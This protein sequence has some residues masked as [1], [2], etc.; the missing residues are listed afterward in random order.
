M[1]I[2]NVEDVARRVQYVAAA[3]QTAFDYTF[4][5]FDDDDLV[6][7]VDGVVQTKT[8]H[9]TLDG[10]GED[11]GGTVTF[12]TPMDGDEVV[13][14]Y[15]DTAIQRTSDL[16]QN[17]PLASS[18]LN[19][20]FDRVTV[21]L[22]ELREKIGRAVRFPF[23]AT[24]SNASLEMTPISSWLGKFIRVSSAGVIEAAEVASNLVSLT[25]ST[26][27]QLIYPR[28]SNEI[29]LGVTP[30]YYHY[31]E[32]TP[33][34]YGTSDTDMAPYIN[35][36]IEVME[37][38]GG[39]TVQ[40]RSRTY[41]TTQA[42]VGKANVSIRGGLM[43]SVISVTSANGIT[44]DDY[45]GFGLTMLEGFK[46]VGAAGTTYTGIKVI[47][48]ENIA[49]ELYGFG[50]RDVTV[51]DFNTGIDLRSVRRFALDNVW[52]QDVTTGIR[53]IGRTLLGWLDKVM[54]VYGDGN[55]TGTKRGLYVLTDDYDTGGTQ[56]PE[57]IQ[58][59]NFQSYGFD[60]AV[61]VPFCNVFG[62][63]NFDLDGRVMGIR[64][65]TIQHGGSFSD[66][67]INMVGASATDGMAGEGLASTVSTH[68]GI[69][70]VS[71]LGSTTT[72]CNGIRVN[73]AGNTNQYY[74]HVD[75]GVFDGLTSY[76]ILFNNP[77]PGSI[78]NTHCRSSG[79]TKS[80]KVGSVQAGK[81]VVENNQCAST[82]QTESADAIAGKV[83]VYNNTVSGT[84]HHSADSLD[85]Y[86]EGTW[87][88][89]DASG[90]GLS[91]TSVSATY[92]RVGN[93][94]FARAAF[95]FP[96]TA[97]TAA[98]LIGGLPYTVKNE[99]AARQGMLSYSSVSGIHRALPTVNATTFSL[100]TDNGVQSQNDALTN[101][102]FHVLLQYTIS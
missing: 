15:S 64:W 36:A 14:L 22:Q 23:N 87:T 95:T 90:A 44:F 65:T 10:V 16:Q 79:V 59:S 31:P 19:D 83:R 99:Q 40:L 27:G 73:G 81:V 86:E 39:G 9:Y 13:T 84:A 55:G 52:V 34:R 100:R 8:T 67:F 17:G 80:I 4:P 82:I 57:G 89:A 60:Y 71:V 41:N 38:G 75:G 88:P 25:A 1:A 78:R 33:D 50:I 30:T 47:G 7:E 85:W 45:T 72:A 42:I 53:L 68:I 76:D 48:T 101:G 74:V 29:A 56:P 5:I 51:T 93:M 97:N 12:V 11:A 102:L 3:A 62:M 63:H 49:D 58:C 35:T 92:T 96:A 94:V 28:T 24:A 6:V 2:D 70:N 26:I 54:L 20:E 43:G 46:L 61:D 98:N 69:K 66:G 77:G 18:T 91:F 32:G 37:Q 21:I